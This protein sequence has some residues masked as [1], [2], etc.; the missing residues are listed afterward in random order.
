MKKLL[1][2]NV[3]LFCAFVLAKAQESSEIG[4]KIDEVRKGIQVDF[5]A[6]YKQYLLGNDALKVMAASK[7][8]PIKLFLEEGKVGELRYF[9]ENGA[10]V[11]YI[12]YNVRAAQTTQTDALHPNGDLGLNLTGKGLTIGVYDQTRP[13]PDHAEFGGRV[14]QVDGSSEVISN[15]ATHVTGTL[16]AEGL[17]ENAKGMAYESNGWAFNWEGDISKMGTNAYDKETKPDGHLVS[18]HS[19]GIVLGWYR[20]QNG[21]WKWAGNPSVDPNE[22]YR[23][24]LYTA[25]SKSLDDIAF[26]K[27]YYTMVWAAGNDRTDRG[28]GTRD[29]DGPDDTIGPEGIAKN[30]I[31]VGAVSPFE[32]YNDRSS[33]A[34][35]DFSSWGPTDDGRI[36][37]DLVGVGVGVFSTAISENGTDAYTTLSGTSMA[38][39]NVAGS[40]LLLQQ[41]YAQRNSGD[42]MRSSTLKALAINTALDGGLY[43]GPDYVYGWGILNA[44]A[45]AEMIIEENGSSDL[46]R[47]LT[48]EQGGVY[49]YEIV[50]DG[51]SPIKATIAWTDPSSSPSP[52][53]LNPSNL[54]LVND[55]DMR[56]VD[57]TGQEYFPWSLDPSKGANSQAINSAD[58][59]R[60]NVEQ[61]IISSPTP[62]KYTVRVSHK[63]SLTNGAQEFSLVL[64]AG[65][66]DGADETLYWVGGATGDWSDAANWSETQ[67]GVS[68]NK[69]PDADSRVL[70]ELASGQSTQVNLSENSSAFSVNIFGGGVVNMNMNTFE[71]AVGGG[72]RVSNQLTSISHGEVIFDAADEQDK[73]MEFAG[74]VFEDLTVRIVSGN[75]NL[76]NAELLDRLEI[77]GGELLVGAER[78]E[79]NSL[80]LEQGSV[81]KGNVDVLEFHESIDISNNSSFTFEGNFIFDGVNG[82]LTNNNG[83]I[84]SLEVQSGDLVYNGSSSFISDIYIQNGSMILGSVAGFTANNLVMGQGALLDLSPSKQFNLL[85]NL[86][87]ESTSNSEARIYASQKGEFVHDIYKKY[88]FEF[89]NIDGVDLSGD[90]IVNLG[91]GAEVI[92]ADNWLVQNCEDVLFANF[93]S[94]FNCVGG[95]TEFTNLSEGSISTY[96]WNFGNAGNSDLVNPSFSFS[97]TGEYDVVLTIGNNIQSESFTKTVTISENGLQVPV[98]VVNGSV[99]TSQTLANAYQWYYN[100]A[101][102]PGATNRSYAADNDGMYQVAISD[103][104][105]N[106][107]SE[108]VLVTAIEDEEPSLGTFGVFIGPSPTTGKVNLRI[109]NEYEGELELAVYTLNGREI[110]SRSFYKQQREVNFE[111][112][113][114][115]PAGVYLFMIQMG[116]LVLRS[117]VIKH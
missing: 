90:A 43:E 47:E 26:S 82:S 24:G 67:G 8:V 57:E 18:N 66:V 36:K 86:V 53:I 99:M 77:V 101:K 32:E 103:E 87:V 15:H 12:T 96:T 54:K 60:D 34:I 27:P 107:L 117:K 56:I 65:T 48:L 97:E 17:N 9:D 50:S 93:T 35:S 29:P 69:I 51:I 100:G 92:N 116:D 42:Y 52:T 106:R 37:P 62:K 64:K 109:N 21:T 31:T 63:G 28:D 25:K 30:V 13:K 1:L 94:A 22:D 7:G 4:R 76:T 105:C 78:L 81:L 2:I 14:R 72:F 23:F 33:L 98:I 89:L 10:P 102:I 84:N 91:L 68:A 39:P 115:Q 114:S 11:Y 19:Y 70:F 111:Y 3:F 38:S 49:E 104:T 6:N 112:Q 55:L 83:A 46:I 5:D 20:D 108:P 61:V 85:E 71:L 88:C 80:F 74:V 95:S 16:L 58:N 110:S 73:F 40:L 79:L 113:L 44:K 45:A 59:F 75:W 41:L